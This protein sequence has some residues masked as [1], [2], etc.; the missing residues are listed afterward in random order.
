MDSVAKKLSEIEQTA[1]AIVEN[2]E[3]QKHDLEQ[4][5]QEKRNQM[6]DALEKETKKKLEAIRSELQQ[7]MEQLLEKQREQNNQE[8]EV[9]KKDFEAHHTEYAKEIL[10]RIIEVSL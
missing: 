9:L 10:A 3:N 2:A 7:D 8:I 6:D 1:Q 4:K 5:M